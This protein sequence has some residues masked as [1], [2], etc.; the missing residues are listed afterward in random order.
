MT[1]SAFSERLLPPYSGQVQIAQSETYRA[2]TIDGQVWEI[3]YV[4][5]SHIRVA[6]LSAAD[7]K[8]R[9]N[10]PELQEHSTKD[11][12]LA[13]MLD[14]LTDIALPFPAT[15]HYEYWLLDAVDQLPL[16]LIYSCS[17][18]A[19]MD[20]FPSRPEW[21]ALPSAVMP[22]P[23]TPQEQDNNSAPVNY[24]LESLV[25]ERSG[26]RAQAQWFDRSAD[27]DL[28]FPPLM[29]REDW[30]A[31]E[32][33]ELCRRYIERQAPRLL[34]LHGLQAELRSRLEI[35]SQSQ[36][37]EVARFANLYPE[38]IDQSLIQSLRV[39][40]RLREAAGGGGQ[41]ALHNRRDGIL[42]M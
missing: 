36:A 17:Q 33:T 28:A 6:T 40:A 9:A 4:K 37:M 7:I 25:A 42:Y 27:T 30:L 34:M 5:R 35:C 18:E 26:T 10:N 15:D 29:I 2:L 24:R 20:K 23:K 19:Q 22:V 41:P 8:A 11:P 1:I 39:Q 3:Q 16:A 21:T 13:E 31:P 32:D 14:Y 12:Q 38:H